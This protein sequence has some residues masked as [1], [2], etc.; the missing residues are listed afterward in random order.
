MPEKLPFNIDLNLN[1]TTNQFFIKFVGSGDSA[2][3]SSFQKVLT[4][5]IKAAELGMF[6]KDTGQSTVEFINKVSPEDPVVSVQAS[7]EYL[8]RYVDISFVRIF[9]NLL[10]QIPFD[11]EFKMTVSVQSLESSQNLRLMDINRFPYQSWPKTT[12]F[13]VICPWPDDITFN[14]VIRFNFCRA[15]SE[16]ETQVIEDA[17]SVWEKIV[18]YGGYIDK[19]RQAAERFIQDSESYPI[20]PGTWEFIIY[21]FTAHEISLAS[22]IRFTIRFHY[23]LCPLTCF[24]IQP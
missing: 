7:A 9:I 21:R 19:P 1:P 14:P 20:S 6:A 10:F 2:K 13:D 24:E 11:P 23:E 4:V 8:I 12:P 22:L 18:K 15:L 17:I 3:L 16:S 5:L